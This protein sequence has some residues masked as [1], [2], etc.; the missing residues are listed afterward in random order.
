MAQDPS[1]KPS[2]EATRWPVVCAVVVGLSGG[3]MLSVPLSR[4]I[5][6]EPSS[7]ADQPLAAA[8]PAPL[9]NPFAGWTGFGAR[10]VVVLGRDRSGSNTDV[11]FT[12]RVNGTTTTITQIPRDSYI[13]AEGFGGMKLN[14]LMA[15]GGV[16]AVERELS[17]L[18]NRPIRHH[19][20]VRLDAIETLANLVGGIEVD[21]PKRLYYVDRSQ[22]LV[23]DLQPGPQLLKGKDLEGFLRWRNDGRGDFGRLERQQLAL[24]GL[25]VQ[26][27]QP[28]NL[29]RLP[30][31]ISAAGQ[32]LETDLG[33]MELGGLIT[34]M[35][36]TDLNASRLNAV[37]FNADGIS[38]LD[39]EW[40]AKASS[41]ADASEASSQRFRFLF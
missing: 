20:V 8:Q 17:R 38:Y 19:I 28:Q 35:G 14:A 25:F 26:M 22:N 6:T 41:G 29:I 40:P 36:T 1:A 13:D 9:A 4:L 30:A 11:I 12:V 7:T 34:A 33:P 21:V 27:K 23:I 15:Y 24:K 3:L 37:P 2:S 18:M 32:A 16:E 10:E 5:N 39:T 31:L